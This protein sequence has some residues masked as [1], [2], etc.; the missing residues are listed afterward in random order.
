MYT[1]KSI[2]EIDNSEGPDVRDS[3]HPYMAKKKKREREMPPHK[4]V[5]LSQEAVRGQK[6]GDCKSS[7]LHGSIDK[8]VKRRGK[9]CA[10]SYLRPP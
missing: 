2:T 6:P 4:Y 3:S 1:Q 9:L 10:L 7:V 8:M 5:F